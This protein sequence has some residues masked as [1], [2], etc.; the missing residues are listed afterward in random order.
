MKVAAFTSSSTT[1]IPSFGT[2]TSTTTAVSASVNPSRRAFLTN[3]AATTSTTSIMAGF[4]VLNFNEHST[5][6]NCI[7]CGPHDN[8]CDCPTCAVGHQAGCQC[9]NCVSTH[10]LG[11]QCVSCVT[12]GPLSKSLY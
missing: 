9:G 4:Q 1:S 12:T 11:C 5:G 6:C 2:A 3:V 8:G 7:N 10:S